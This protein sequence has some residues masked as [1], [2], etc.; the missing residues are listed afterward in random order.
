M[1]LKCGNYEGASVFAYFDI[2]LDTMSPAEM[3]HLL[4]HILHQA[5][6]GHPRADIVFAALSVAESNAKQFACAQPRRAAS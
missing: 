5:S 1:K 6:P 4:E 2:P 3:R